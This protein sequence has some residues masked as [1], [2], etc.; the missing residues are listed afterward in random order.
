MAVSC[1]L[2]S[3]SAI[4]SCAV[5]DHDWN[6]SNCCFKDAT[7][8]WCLSEDVFLSPS[9]LTVSSCAFNSSLSVA[10][11][12]SLA[13]TSAILSCAVADHDW[14]S[15]R[16][17]VRVVFSAL[18]CSSSVLRVSSSGELCT[19]DSSSTS[20]FCK[21]SFIVNKELT[22]SVILSS[23]FCNSSRSEVISARFFSKPTMIAGVTFE[24]FSSIIGSALDA[25]SPLVALPL[26][27]ICSSC[28]FFSWT[29]FVNL[30]TCVTAF[31]IHSFAS[32]L[33]CRRLVNSSSWRLIAC[34]SSSIDEEVS[35]V[36]GGAA[37]ISSICC[38]SSRVRAFSW[39]SSSSLACSV[40]SASS[41]IRAVS[42]RR[43]FSSSW[44]TSDVN[45]A[46]LFDPVVEAIEL[47]ASCND[48]VNDSFSLVI[49]SILDTAIDIHSFAALPSS[50][51]RAFSSRNDCTS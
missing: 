25:S 31:A 8:S 27:D 43:E 46:A 32:A 47:R 5:A 11:S 40:I 26:V 41:W 33:A 39:M 37:F 38:S 21:S 4:L 51:R 23:L 10:V 45:S 16:F 24:A 50:R 9:V 28:S 44:W 20:F 22:S 30:S 29:S 13:S 49:S 15:A 2:A 18:T 12:C 1:S 35:S 3:T 34:F 36:A 7:S 17:V 6:S 42:M 14:N 19:L 48:I